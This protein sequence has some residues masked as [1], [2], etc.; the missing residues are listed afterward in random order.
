M[1]C[2]AVEQFF[3][4]LREHEHERAVVG[5]ER[6]VPSFD[7]VHEMLCSEVGGQEF[8]VVCAVPCLCSG[9]LTREKTKWLPRFRGI[10]F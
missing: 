2:L 6:S 1:Q 4:F 9:K 10:L 5:V 8:S 7:G 3:S